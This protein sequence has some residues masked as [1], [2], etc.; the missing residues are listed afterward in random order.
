MT[1]IRSA[2]QF[3]IYAQSIIDGLSEADPSVAAEKILTELNDAECRVALTLTL[4]DWLRTRSRT[5]GNKLRHSGPAKPQQPS[6]RRA[7]QRDWWQDVLSTTLSVGTGYKFLRDCT[8]DD[9]FAAAEIRYDIAAANGVEA[10]KWKATAELMQERKYATVADMSADE[11][12]HIWGS[13][14]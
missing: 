5:L 14:S 9:L 7:I 6:A 3:R 4:T 8:N 13:L 10:N 11:W 12:R 1:E 2:S